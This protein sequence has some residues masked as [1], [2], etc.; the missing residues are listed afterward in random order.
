MT[1]RTSATNGAEGCKTDLIRRVSALRLEV[2]PPVRAGDLLVGQARAGVPAASRIRR[3]SASTARGTRFTSRLVLAPRSGLSAV[4]GPARR[5][6]AARA[7]VIYEPRRPAGLALSHRD[8]PLHVREAFYVF[9]SQRGS[10]KV[11]DLPQFL[12]LLACHQG[13][14]DA[15]RSRAGGTANAMDVVLGLAWKVVIHHVGDTV[16]VYASGDDIGRYQYP[17][18]PVFEVVECLLTLSLA[19]I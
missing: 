1:L 8:D 14:R 19:P 11:F 13:K 17:A 4:P 15:G 16:H 5:R 2:A 3:R 7:P 6:P 18:T 10:Q 9:T 12:G